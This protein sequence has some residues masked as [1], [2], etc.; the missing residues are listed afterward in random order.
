MI[1]SFNNL[2]SSN[3]TK[4]IFS[5]VAILV[6]NACNTLAVQTD[7]PEQQVSQLLA[8]KRFN[9]ALQIV[10]NIPKTHSQYSQLHAQKNKIQQQKDNYIRQV[11]S[12]A[13]KHKQN[14]KWQQAIS[15]YD[16]ALKNLPHEKTLIDA[17]TALIKERNIKVND[18]RKDLLF[19]KAKVLIG[20]QP[21]YEKLLSLV[22]NDALA[23]KEISFYE[24]EKEA[25]AEL[26]MSC[27]RHG[28]TIQDYVLAERCLKLSNQLNP[29]NT[30][31]LLLDEVTQ[32]KNLIQ[33][34]KEI[35]LLMAKYKSYYESNDLANAKQSLKGVLKIDKTRP[36][37][38]K[39]MRALQQKI[40]H[41][42]DAGLRKGKQLYSQGKIKQALQIWR[43]LKKIAPKH[44][45]LDG[46]ISRARIV[47]RNLKELKKQR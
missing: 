44:N 13:L 2:C 25:L 8:D 41:R 1:L 21:L 33:K 9:D 45:E 17:R 47:E 12:T 18:L 24:D 30:K 7:N 20:Y 4:V 6:L 19:Q 32:K 3:L 43:S 38:L 34:N 35:N 39:L 22:P 31:K 42:I 27:G 11:K 5:L 10:N 37:A 15:T 36:Q 23:H 29:A 14:N 26:L 28:V 40:N 16:W 46:L